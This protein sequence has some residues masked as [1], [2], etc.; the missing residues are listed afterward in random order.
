MFFLKRLFNLCWWGIFW[1]CFY[2][3]FWFVLETEE[4][5]NLSKLQKNIMSFGILGVWVMERK[6]LIFFCLIMHFWMNNAMI[7]LESLTA[8]SRGW[9]SLSESPVVQR[10][11]H[12]QPA[13]DGARD[14]WVQHHQHPAGEVWR[15]RE[16]LPRSADTQ[17]CQR[18]SCTEALHEGSAFCQ[19]S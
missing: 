4:K 16:A 6:H 17:G 3:S 13:H 14:P 18:V 10:P 2:N 9:P 12:L 1:M 5:N 19:V 8:F 15:Q 11:V 7:C